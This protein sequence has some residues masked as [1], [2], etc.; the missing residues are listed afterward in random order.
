MTPAPIK[1]SSPPTRE[2][3]EIP[4]L[5]E[6]EH[7]LALDKPAGVLTSPDRCET[8]RPSLMKLL[9]AGIAAGKPWAVDRRLSYLTNAHRLEFETSGVLLLAKSKPVLVKLAEL[10]GSEKPCLYCLAL[11]QGAPP[12]A[13]FEVNAKLGPHPTIPGLVQVDPRR[14]K[15]SRTLVEVLE[16]FRGYALLR[17][18]A[19]TRR[20]YQVPAHLR[21]TGLPLVG[22]E[23]Y[24][25]RPLL[26]SRLKRAYHLKEGD[27]ERPLVSRAALHA[28][29]LTLPHPVTG[30]TLTVTAPWPKDLTVA[31]KYLRRFALA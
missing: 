20:A 12:E 19:L 24:G 1:L 28:S 10:F 17:C 22:A 31:V 23:R 2:F 26:L 15:R 25:G 21:H 18:E 3:W 14:G 5:F 16:S 6:D 4:V 29:E 9:H 7:L 30:D 27:T 8:E 11:V 13:R